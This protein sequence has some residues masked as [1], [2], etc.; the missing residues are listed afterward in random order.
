MSKILLVAVLIVG[1]VLGV[2]LVGQRTGFFSK[3]SASAVPRNIKITNISDNAFTVTW[4]TDKAATGFVSLANESSGSAIFD[5]RD[6]SPVKE[7]MTHHVTFK[8]LEPKTAYSFKITSGKE[9]YDDQ[10]KSFVQITAPTTQKP[11]EMPQPV[12]GKVE[13]EKGGFP[14]EA[15]VYLK[16]GQSS[17]L[18]TYA[19]D[20]GKWL[21]TLNNARTADLTNYVTV[22]DSG[23]LE[24]RVEAGN[25]GNVSK[26]IK[27]NN[28][29]STI[30]LMLQSPIG[31]TSL[32]DINND[33]VINIFDYISFY[34][35]RKP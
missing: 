10:G 4:L 31:S 27:G 17:L 24:L 5:D 35:K 21:M 34:L 12:F 13:K 32:S 11:P 6:S 3:A 1:L 15:I 29:T 20:E 2:Y 26:T 14:D 7:R 19:R 16:A 8:N 33:G 23:L 30:S 25:D 9:V 22:S 28:R 18:S